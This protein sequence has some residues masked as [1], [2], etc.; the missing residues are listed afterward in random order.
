MP[1]LLCLDTPL[2]CNIN[3]WL[4]LTVEMFYLYTGA[5]VGHMSILV[6]TVGNL[7]EGHSVFDLF[8]KPAKKETI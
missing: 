4:Y 8:F 5:Q 3:C 2:T 1:C 7:Q 6:C